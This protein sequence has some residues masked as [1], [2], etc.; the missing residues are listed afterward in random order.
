M[1]GSCLVT[2]PP[3][4]PIEP[5]AII[6]S[7]T[8]HQLLKENHKRDSLLSQLGPLNSVGKGRSFRPQG[9]SMQWHHPDSNYM[10]SQLCHPSPFIFFSFKINTIK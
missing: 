4:P 3:L 10:L 6:L 9:S 2:F 7:H 5:V 8:I 1:V